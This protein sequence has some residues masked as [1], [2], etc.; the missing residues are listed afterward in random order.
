MAEG[1]CFAEQDLVERDAA[2]GC[3]LEGALFIEAGST[4]V[5][6]ESIR[7]SSPCP[8]GAGSQHV[9]GPFT[10]H[11]KLE[12]AGA[13]YLLGICLVSCCSAFTVSVGWLGSYRE[14]GP[15]TMC[16]GLEEA[17]S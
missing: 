5:R 9:R 1:T 6:G 3:Y 14:V 17:A 2:E 10:Q 11:G 13:R 16:S 12:R 15:Q 7:E 4:G 8:W